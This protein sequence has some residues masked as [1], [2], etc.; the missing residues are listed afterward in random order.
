VLIEGV[1]A[2]DRP[3][4][5]A[6]TIV[7]P[8]GRGKLE[9]DFTACN[10]VAPQRESF[11]YKLEGFDETWTSTS[12]TRA[13]YYT[14]LP[15]GRYRFR[16]V[17]SDGGSPV[18]ASEASISLVWRPAFYQTPWF[19]T[20]CAAGVAGLVWGALLLS[21]RQTRARYAVLLVERTR[22]AREMHDT[23]IQGCVGVST[24]LEAASRFQR[25]NLE[26]ASQLLDQARAQV[27]VT[28]DE[29]RHAVWD[30]RHAPAADSSI[31]TLCELAQKLGREHRIDIQTEIVGERVPLD[32][33]AD[34]TLLLVGR[35]ALRNAVSHAQPSRIAVRIVFSASEV[36]LEVRD[37]GT[38]FD[39]AGN[40]T[41]EN[42]HFGI[43]GMRERVEQ[44]G[45][46]FRLDTHLGGGT[47]VVVRIPL[48]RRRAVADVAADIEL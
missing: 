20:L 24:L 7:I 38:G 21:A 13:A 26:E 12:R 45:G 8:P 39:L 22:L 31:S 32:P 41:G 6:E 30:L 34:R 48:V 11:R 19:Y 17:A 14:N 28:L 44:I 3:V 4:P 10:L 33:V 1:L 15:P 5:L 29:A 36:R 47:V 35:E 27:K 40:S 9:I 2:G 43:V 25:S 23:V 37:D 46:S 18:N 42:G 16:V